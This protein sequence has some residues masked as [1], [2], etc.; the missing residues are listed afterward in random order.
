MTLDVRSFTNPANGRPTSPFRVAVFDR[1]DFDIG[2]TS[3]SN[4]QNGRLSVQ[5]SEPFLITE[6][7][8]LRTNTD[9][10]TAPIVITI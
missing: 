4:D 2:V 9:I 5:M 6:N 10:T 1:E 3:G 7:A 8:T